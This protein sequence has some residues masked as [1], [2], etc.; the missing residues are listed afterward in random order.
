MLYSMTTHD[1]SSCFGK[2]NFREASSNM[3][4]SSSGIG[5]LCKRS[6]I[7][8]D[9]NDGVVDII[10]FVMALGFLLPRSYS[11]LNVSSMDIPQFQFLCSFM[12][13]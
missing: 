8:F 6:G 10:V 4:T 5:S 2:V 1:A 12:W 3:K 11:A 13:W 7:T 9:H